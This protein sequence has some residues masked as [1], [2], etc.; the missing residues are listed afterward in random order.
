MPEMHLKQPEFTYTVSGPFSKNQV[1]IQKFMQTEDTRHI[2]QNDLDESSFQHNMAYGSYKDL[3]KRTKSDKV[4]RDKAFKIAP[5]KKYNDYGKGLASIVYKFFDERSTGRDAK[6]TPN[7]QLA[8]ELHKPI[9]R[10]SGAL[11]LLIC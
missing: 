7:Q 5:D 4:L 2:Y 8:D 11:V 10:C 6:S 1:R 9:I 3:V